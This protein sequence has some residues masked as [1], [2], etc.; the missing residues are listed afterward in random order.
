M[1]KEDFTDYLKTHICYKPWDTISIEA[2]GD[3]IQCCMPWLPKVMG[4]LFEN[5]MDEIIN[6]ATTRE[7]Q[8]SILDGSFRFCNAEMCSE[9]HG[10]RLIP[11][12]DIL[13]FPRRPYKI[14]FS[15]DRSCNLW[16]P[17][18]RTTRIQN[19]EG[20]EYDRAKWMNDRI[21]DYML[22]QC[23]YG[24][25]EI[26]ITGSGDAIGSKIYREMLKSLDGSQFPDLS[27]NLMTNGVLF[28]PKVWDSLHKIW[29]NITLLDISVDAGSKEI[30]QQVRPPGLWDQLLENSKFLGECAKEYRNID[31]NYGFVVQQAN[32]LD[33][34]NFVE[35][36]SQFEKYHLLNF[37]LVNDWQTWQDFTPHA[38]WKQHHPEYNTF[39]SMVNRDEL[40]QDRVFMGS[41]K[42]FMV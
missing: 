22:E 35:V 12:P 5:S 11:R 14:R 19:N 20:P 27:I 28:T 36:F 21:V 41:L 3:V 7:V 29:N 32:Y 37:T 6:S 15:N 13:Q 31:I 25:V 9:I 17:S 23:N 10:K 26:W 34:V 42:R 8:E 30:Y 16:C 40:K 33:M 4:N 24:P 38:V 2:N 18:C 1:S 39:V